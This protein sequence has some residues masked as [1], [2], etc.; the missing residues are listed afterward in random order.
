[1]RGHTIHLRSHLQLSDQ[2]WNQILFKP[3]QKTV[4]PSALWNH[5]CL[6]EQ[7]THMYDTKCKRY[8]KIQGEKKS[9]LPWS[10]SLCSLPKSYAL[11]SVNFIC[12][13]YKSCRYI[14]KC[15][16][17]HRFFFPPS[18]VKPNND[19]F[20]NSLRAQVHISTIMKFSCCF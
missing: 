1:M 11:L 15:I 13:R 14:Y 18:T 19:S 7:M 12:Y 10:Y 17:I 9:F 3:H 6:F 20:S 5:L 2:V 4:A 16:D 8:S